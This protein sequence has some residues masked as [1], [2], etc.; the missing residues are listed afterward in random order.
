M[1]RVKCIVLISEIEE[2][3]DFENSENITDDTYGEYCSEEIKDMIDN[4]EKMEDFKGMI[5]LSI[6]C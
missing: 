3:E 4:P 1:G 5:I 6:H 2:K